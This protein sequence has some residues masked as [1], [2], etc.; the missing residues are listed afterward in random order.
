[1]HLNQR[2]VTFV[3]ISRAPLS[4][5][6]AF[7]KRLGWSFKWASS[8]ENDF[9]FDYHIS[10]TKDDLAKGSI[11]YNYGLVEDPKYHNDELAGLSVFYRD[12]K[13]DIFHTYSSYARGID[14]VN[15]AY[16]YLD[17]V[18]KGRDEAG[19]PHTMTWV[20]LRDEYGA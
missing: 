15:T 18:P 10:F 7:A 5:L 9:N 4:K 13:G 3:A 16:H 19:L 20:R 17:L 11:Y 14:M 12:D 1:V 8:C 2:D 6:Q